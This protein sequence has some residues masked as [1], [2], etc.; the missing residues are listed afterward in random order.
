MID[1]PAAICQPVAAGKAMTGK[2]ATGPAEERAAAA[3]YGG[4][5]YYRAG[6]DLFAFPAAYA[7]A[8][9]DL[10][11]PD[12]ARL[13]CVTR[14][15][16]MAFAFPASAMAEA[17]AQSGAPPPR[18]PAGG[19]AAPGSPPDEEVV[20]RVSA[21]HY[22]PHPD[23]AGMTRTIAAVRRADVRQG[24]LHDLERFPAEGGDHLVR[25]SEDRG[26]LVRLPAVPAAPDARALMWFQTPAWSAAVE[27]PACA[28]PR[29]DF[30][31]GAIDAF[32]A[33]HVVKDYFR[34]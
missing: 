10:A 33:K 17:V 5:L 26:V 23:F 27:V 3:R 15:R 24:F 4:T 8:A 14:S 28:V 25:I 30:V 29:W 12:L 22:G 1:V 32:V 31:Y 34:R 20:I 11:A 6:N 13:G 18:A 16:E 9:G 19:A 21:F 7:I 2:A